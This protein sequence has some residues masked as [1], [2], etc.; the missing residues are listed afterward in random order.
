MNAEIGTELLP[1]LQK[2][3]SDYLDFSKGMAPADTKEFN[4]YHTA[5]K[6]A[7]LHL[8]LL[9]KLTQ[10][11]TGTPPFIPDLSVLLEQ[12]KKELKINDFSGISVDLG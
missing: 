9:V 10:K 3:L 2:A 6:A 11:E 8:A 7:L 1:A 4:A 12:A 5:C